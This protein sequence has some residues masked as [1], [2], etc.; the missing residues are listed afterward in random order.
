MRLF[1]PTE[2]KAIKE[3]AQGGKIQNILKVAGKYSP[4]S[5]IGLAT[6]SYMGA[7]MLGPAGAAIAPIVGGASN[8]AATQ[9]RKSD[10][11]KLAALMRA[12][13]PKGA[14]NE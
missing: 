13:T 11:N 6:G 4:E 12:G 8:I 5:M 14:K 10:V 7:Q 2:Q 3:A 9:I 1:T